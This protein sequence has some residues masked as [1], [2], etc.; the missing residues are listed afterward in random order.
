MFFGIVVSLEQTNQPGHHPF[1]RT[2][3]FCRLPTHIS[4]ATAHP[5][6]PQF[7][8]TADPAPLTSGFFREHH[9]SNCAGNFRNRTMIE[10]EKLD[11]VDALVFGLNRTAEWRKKMAIF[12][13]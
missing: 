13:Q 3:P 11:C 7:H 4:G 5:V 10:N 12:A 9:A 6:P 2:V 1:H 8:E